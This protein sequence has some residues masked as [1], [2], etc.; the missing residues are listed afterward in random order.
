MALS[1]IIPSLSDGISSALS[2]LNSE[3]LK[4]INEIRI[5]KNMPLILIIGK[6]T[7]FIT[8]K[9]KLLN[10]F[11]EFSY[12]VNEEEFDV[13]FRR[14]CNYSVH[15][16]IDNLINGF[17][18]TPGGNRVGV[19]STAVK[20]GGEITAVKDITSLNIRIAC[21]VKNCAKPVMNIIFVNELPSIIV[22]SKTCGGKTTFLRDLARLL[23]SGFNNKY[24]KVA[25]IDERNEIAFKD[26][27]GIIADV[28][29]NC[30]ALTGFPKAKGIEIAVR[31]LS[32]DYI[33]CD[34]IAT[35]SEVESIKDGFNSGVSFAVSV[36]A[37]SKQD[38]LNKPIVKSL[39]DTK[40]FDYIVLLN[41]YTNDFE[42]LEVG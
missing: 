14:L 40:E 26:S 19:C 37:D 6:N 31:T 13:I 20:K 22:A 42:I 36:H 12:I 3:A 23:S 32:P 8:A 30:D 39:T 28:G 15:C 29:L 33:I 25:V 5:R 21:E 9:G 24:R 11:S 7:Y 35:Q 16:E 4:Q 17:I 18:T 10:H 41:D 2:E 38:L 34:E 1:T 27:D